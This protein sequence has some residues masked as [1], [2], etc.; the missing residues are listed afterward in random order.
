MAQPVAQDR[1][2]A[3]VFDTNQRKQ[4]PQ[5]GGNISGRAGDGR[6]IKRQF[7]RRRI[8]GE[9]LHPIQIRYFDASRRGLLKMVARRRSLLDYLAHTAN[10][11]YKK[12]IGNLGLRK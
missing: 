12:V 8:G 9:R 4:R 2:Q 1:A 10:D 6:R 11:R 3:C 5:S 7:G